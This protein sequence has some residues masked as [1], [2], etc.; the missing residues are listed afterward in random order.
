MAI[1]HEACVQG[2]VQAQDNRIAQVLIKKAARTTW[3]YAIASLRSAQEWTELYLAIAKA[4]S[5]D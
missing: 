4:N 3:R 2:N 5:Q 1:E